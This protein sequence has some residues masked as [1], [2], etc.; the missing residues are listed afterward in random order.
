MKIISIL[1]YAPDHFGHDASICVLKD[2]KVELNFELER[3]SRIKEDGRITENFLK[4][5]EKI[6]DI[7]ADCFVADIETCQALI[8]IGFFDSVSFP[9]KLTEDILKHP[10]LSGTAVLSKNKKKY[11]LYHV[12]HHFAHACSAAFT[13]PF[14]NA[15]VVTADAGGHLL[16]FSTSKLE[17]GFL[18]KF[19]GTWTNPI[20]YLWAMIPSIYS[21]KQPGSLMAI[22][23]YGK[24]NSIIFNKLD[25]ALELML[26]KKN[27]FEEA[28]K[29]LYNILFSQSNKKNHILNAAVPGEADLA[30]NLQAITDKIF[31]LW[32]YKEKLNEECNICF[33]GGL[34]LNCIGNSNAML[35]YENSKIHVP[36]NPNDSGLALGG[37]LAVFYVLGNRRYQPDPLFSPYLGP[38]YSKFHYEEAL[39]MLKKSNKSNY[40]ICQTSN[41]EIADIVQAGHI[42]A[43]FF[44]RSEAGP[45][46]LGHR[47]FIAR[48]DIKNLRLK[49][50]KIKNRE[51]YRPFA[52]IILQEH[53]STLLERV[54]LNSYYMNTSAL[55]KESWKERLSGVIHIDGT[56]RPQLI[57]AYMC[58]DT[59][60]LVQK[61][62]LRTGIPAI[63][64]T[65]FNVQEPLVE[66]PL[67]AVR[68]FNN[69]N[70]ECIFLQLGQ[71]LIKRI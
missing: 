41:D 60:D 12:H 70:N 68:T 47:S 64:N 52:P 37:A 56:T 15:H 16:N 71:Y 19:K 59:Y 29:I 3:Y 17:K 44:G 39:E 67:D 9:E 49:M 51:W 5:V 38:N 28:K 34:A 22:A 62:Y 65:S 66:T 46:A 7:E 69:L 6:T 55:I 10:I 53:A 2:G 36:P 20:G 48:P 35:N 33:S 26:E 42:V 45:R 11:N 8:K 25:K 40:K 13:S 43:R 50:N 18:R 32:F 27:N 4:Y 61:I 1:S 23:A 24:P 54:T 30:Y 57:S 21:S 31:T 58:S 14:E 63:L